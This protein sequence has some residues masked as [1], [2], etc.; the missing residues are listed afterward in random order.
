MG[1][2]KGSAMDLSAQMA[3]LAAKDEIRELLYIYCHGTDRMDMALVES[4]FH[5]DAELDYGFFKGDPKTLSKFSTK[6]LTRYDGT[7]HC[8]SNVMIRV[9]GEQASSVSYITALHCNGK[10]RSGNTDMIGYG[11]YIDRHERR[12]G[13][14]KIAQRTVLFDWTLEFPSTFVWPEDFASNVGRRGP[15]D[16]AS[17]ALRNPTVRV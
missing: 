6:F 3:V 4:L 13:A 15:G 11:R 7:H 2:Q 5:E 8:L 14:W 9:D 10:S 1:Q 16:A 17:L 12:Q